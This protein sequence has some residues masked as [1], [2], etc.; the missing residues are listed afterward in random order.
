MVRVGTSEA[1][2][3]DAV[4]NP[5]IGQ[6]S[7]DFQGPATLKKDAGV[8]PPGQLDVTHSPHT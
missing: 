7:Q 4:Q 6:E 5:F 3:W 8:V 1:V 2:G